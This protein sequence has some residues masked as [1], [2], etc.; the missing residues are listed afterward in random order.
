MIS[1]HYVIVLQAFLRARS[2]RVLVV[3]IGVLEGAQMWLEQ[4]GCTF[5]MVLDPQRKVGTCVF[6][7]INQLEYIH[8]N[9]ITREFSK[10]RTYLAS[11]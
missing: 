9:C 6:T 5:E 3:S 8:I 2:L 1:F 7:P 4:T 10:A 11:A